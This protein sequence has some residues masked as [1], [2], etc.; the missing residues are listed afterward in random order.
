[1]G[2][3]II[4]FIVLI[5]T[6]GCAEYHVPEPNIGS[7]ASFEEKLVSIDK[8]LAELADKRRFNGSIVISRNS[9]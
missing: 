1:M 9:I 3:C 2:K 4:A 5:L 7:T 6:I 8:W